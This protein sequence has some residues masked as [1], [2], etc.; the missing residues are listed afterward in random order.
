MYKTKNALR[1]RR[2]VAHTATRH[3]HIEMFLI[4]QHKAPHALPLKRRKSMTLF[5]SFN[6]Q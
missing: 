5:R 4:A 6:L 1:L 2:F 3:T